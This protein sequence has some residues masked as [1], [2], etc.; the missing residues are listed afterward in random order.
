MCVLE[1]LGFL[2]GFVSSALSYAKDRQRGRV[3]YGKY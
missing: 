1:L 2:D 3:E